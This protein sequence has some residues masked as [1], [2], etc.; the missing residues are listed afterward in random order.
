MAAAL[1]VW[2]LIPNR[3]SFSPA[4]CTRCPVPP[5]LSDPRYFNLFDVQSV[6]G[7]V[8][9]GQLSYN[10]T[11]IDAVLGALRPLVKNLTDLGLI[12]RAYVC[13]KIGAALEIR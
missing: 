10:Q 8:A 1:A 7:R 13:E 6:A 5:R 4:V 3:S 11:Q 2:R 9:S 12:D